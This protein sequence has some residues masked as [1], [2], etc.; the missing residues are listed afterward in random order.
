MVNYLPKME[1]LNVNSVLALNLKERK[2]KEASGK[3]ATVGLIFFLNG[4]HSILL[5]FTF[6]DG[7]FSVYSVQ[8]VAERFKQADLQ[9]S[10]HS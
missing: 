10:K 6:D 2:S 1:I 3:L 9:I 8:I 4:I 5:S 7:I